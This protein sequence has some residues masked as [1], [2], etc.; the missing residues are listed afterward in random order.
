MSMC[1]HPWVGLDIS[2]QGEFK[3][4]CKYKDVLG[5][6]FNEYESSTA[7]LQLKEDFK[8]GVRNPGCYRCWQDEDAGIESKRLLDNKY[9]FNNTAPDLTSLKVVGTTFGNTCNLACRTCGSYASSKWS[10]EAKQVEDKFPEVVIHNHTQF[11]R[12]PEFISQ[13]NKRVQDVIHF[14]FAGGEPFYADSEAHLSLLSELVSSGKSR[15][16]SLH[17]ITNG[18]KFPNSDLTKAAWPHF[19]K[20]DIQVS[21]DGIRDQFEYTRWPAK[22]SSLLLI[23][24]KLEDYRQQSHNVQLSISHT[25]SIFNVWD[26]PETLAWFKKNRLPNPYLGLVSK[27]EHFSITVFPKSS[28]KEIDSKLSV[29]PDLAP[30]VKALWARDDS[31]LLDLTAKYVKIHDTRRQQSFAVTFPQTYQLLGNQCQTLYQLY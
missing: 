29:Y 5:S 31:H 27:P 19:K 12:D 4:C 20:V 7:L 25:V 3:P 1:Y 14:E 18:T 15:D 22:W 24:G 16:I 21:I 13:F 11:Y 10:Q 30:I 26:L 8:N 6:T 2:P 9:V 23:L 17:Y 28:K